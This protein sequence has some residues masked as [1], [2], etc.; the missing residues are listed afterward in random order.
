MATDTKTTNESVY[1]DIIR[2]AHFG[3]NL[4]STI[5]YGIE[6]VKRVPEIRLALENSFTDTVVKA[7]PIEGVKTSTEVVLSM[8]GT[9]AQIC[10]AAKYVTTVVGYIGGGVTIMGTRLDKWPAWLRLTL[11]IVLV[12][13]LIRIGLRVAGKHKDYLMDMKKKWDWPLSLLSKGGSFVFGIFQLYLFF[14][15]EN[16]P[17]GKKVSC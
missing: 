12:F 3:L 10:N 6:K 17:A 4:I 2:C 5:S 13:A 14:K 7:T 9:A 11:Q 1:E 15:A 16:I 8:L